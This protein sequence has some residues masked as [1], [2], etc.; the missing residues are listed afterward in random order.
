MTRTRSEKLLFDEA[1][2][3]S[4][5]M[6]VLREG[7]LDSMFDHFSCDCLPKNELSMDVGQYPRSER[8]ITAFM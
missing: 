8:G 5:K 2:M 7:Y 3:N 4:F 6:L 1:K